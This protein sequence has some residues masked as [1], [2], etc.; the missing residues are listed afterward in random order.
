MAL[1]CTRHHVAEDVG[2]LQSGLLADFC[3]STTLTALTTL[4]ASIP[5]PGA[6]DA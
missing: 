2:G 4:I 1:V 6:R 3:L 5:S